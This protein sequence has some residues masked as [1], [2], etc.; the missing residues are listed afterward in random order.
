MCA[1]PYT[2]D[3]YLSVDLDL[4][5]TATGIWQMQANLPDDDDL[6]WMNR[7]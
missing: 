6:K 7:L 2:H 3:I 5:P 4:D 1:R